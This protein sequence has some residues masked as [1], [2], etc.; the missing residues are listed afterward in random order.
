MGGILAWPGGRPL[1]AHGWVLCTQTHTAAGTLASVPSSHFRFPA[2]LSSDAE[3]KVWRELPGTRKHP[4]LPGNKGRPR[5]AHYRRL[6]PNR[7]V[8]RGA[9]A[10][11]SLW[12][13]AACPRAGSEA[14]RRICGHRG[15]TAVTLQARSLGPQGAGSRC[16]WG[17]MPHKGLQD[18]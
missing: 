15:N 18:T 4:T 13:G 10:G 5:E 9:A 8:G 3:A 7:W 1:P 14:P 12:E 2:G 6:T 16:C 17:Q 11:P